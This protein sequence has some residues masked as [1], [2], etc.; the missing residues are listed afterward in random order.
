M[1]KRRPSLATIVRLTAWVLAFGS[2]H[3]DPPAFE[4]VGF[5][6]HGG[7]VFDYPL[8]PR[9]WQ[10]ADYA[11][12]FGLL[13]K[14]GYDTV[15]VWPLLEAIP[16]PLTDAD[17]AEVR[18][19]RATIQ[20]ARDAG[21]RAWMA[22][23]ANLT[24]PAR[25]AA[26][27]WRERNPYP[28]FLTINFNNA[29]DTAA[30]FAHRAA[31]LAILNNA[32]GYVTIDGDPG[33]YAGATP[34]H[35]A[36]VFRADHATLA[37]HGTDPAH[38]PVIPWAWCGWGAK[39]VWQEPVEPLLRAEL[40]ALRTQLPEPWAL[41]PG[42]SARGHANDRVNMIL[43]DEL[44]LAAR[45]T[46][47]FYEAIEYEPTAPA[48][49]LQFDL[50]RSFFKD[51]SAL[52]GRAPGVMG[53]AQQPVMVLPNLYFFARCARDAAYL[54]KP[55]DAVLDDFAALLGGPPELLRPAWKCLAL[56]LAQLPA[57]LPA[58]LRATTLTGEAAALIPGGPK[59]YLDLLAAHLESR[60]RMLVAMTLP[61]ATNEQ[62]AAA[63]S[64]GTD[65]LVAWWKR[66]HFVAGSDPGT[67]F[68]WAFA[69]S[70]QYTEW[71]NW[72]RAHIADKSAVAILAAQEL[73]KRGTLAPADAPKVVQKLLNP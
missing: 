39:G 58:Q 57:E 15:M 14:M 3:A 38:Q 23:C 73:V 68:R 35:F 5:Y 60:R 44:G 52:R 69:N 22:Q 45:S 54:A 4:H 71:A 66:H 53:N 50:I 18:G 12:M 21:L 25:I 1:N 61:T 29:A 34:Q 41:L 13:K 17:A 8:A 55:D 56:P 24:T 10:R 70:G 30:Y 32:D 51:E 7:W 31:M 65:A 6:T 48:A 63:V 11:G 26:K 2:V 47:L 9:S 64:E 33:S 72:C 62:C 46:L 59:L 36:D 16:M 42:R 49:T 40:E 43:A 27:P 19:F 20:D 37:R 28:V 67:S